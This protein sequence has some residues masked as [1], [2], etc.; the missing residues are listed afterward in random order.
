MRGDV[1]GEPR[2]FGAASR[3]DKWLAGVG[4][5]MTAT[6]SAVQGAREGGT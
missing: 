3:G 1:L 6:D 4:F 2:V 5:F